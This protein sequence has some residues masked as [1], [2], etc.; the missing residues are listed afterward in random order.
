MIRVIKK[1]NTL[2]DFDVQKVVNAVNKSAA[3]VMYNFTPDE[4]N[5]ICKFVTD[6]ATSMDKEEITIAQ[7]H[8]IVESALE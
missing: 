5:F 7:M 4:L 2:E 8:N 3:R 6:K 1:D